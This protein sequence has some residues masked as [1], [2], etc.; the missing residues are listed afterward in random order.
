MID[1]VSDEELSHWPAAAV[2]AMKSEKLLVKAR[3]ATSVVCPGCEQECVMPVHTS[4]T[5]TQN[6]APF[7][8]C[9]KR[10]DINRVAVPI[11]R[12]EQWQASGL[13]IADLLAALLGL[14]RPD[15]S[16]M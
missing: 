2:K 15:P 1:L 9:D 6:A 8:V 13:A 14:R 16:D 10:S 4:P 11:S 12:L 7:I 5:E 3:P